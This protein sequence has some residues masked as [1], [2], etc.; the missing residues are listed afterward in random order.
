M[1]FSQTEVASA[2]RVF[3]PHVGELRFLP[4]AAKTEILQATPID[5]TARL[6]ELTAFQAFMDEVDAARN[7]ILPAFARRWCTKTR[8][9]SFIL[10][11]LCFAF[12]L[13]QHPGLGLSQVRSIPY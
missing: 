7:V 5:V 2:K 4:V 8:C 3:G 12:L 13:S 9:V 6:S 1:G 11:T 10:A